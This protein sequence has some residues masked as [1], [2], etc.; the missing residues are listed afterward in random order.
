MHN[1]NSNDNLFSY[2]C[3][4]DVVVVYTTGH[5]TFRMWDVWTHSPEIPHKEVM[6]RMFSCN[7]KAPETPINWDFLLED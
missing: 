4:K 3:V 5:V 6:R 2:Q 7:R 1:V